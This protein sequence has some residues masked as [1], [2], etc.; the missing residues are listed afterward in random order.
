[1]ESRGRGPLTRYFIAGKPQLDRARRWQNSAAEPAEN[2]EEFL[3]RTRDA[4]TARLPRLASFAEAGLKRDDVPLVVSAAGE[5]GNNCF[6]H[7]LGAWRD[8]PGCWFEAQATGGRLWIC[9]ADRGQGVLR[10]LARADPA[11]AD[12][13]AALTA[14][15]ERIISGRAPENRGNG[16][17]FVRSVVG[18]G[19]NRGL[20]CRSGA[21]V[22]DYG[23]LGPE[24]RAELAGFS[25][26]SEGTITLILWSFA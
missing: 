14:A 20:A 5:V 17:K 25:E 16:L 19:E 10:T 15:F 18:A 26:K 3:C 8:V 4:F 7:N 12:E 13:Q 1:I 11:L 22:V 2:P 6:D 24:C 23:R 9:I 21:G